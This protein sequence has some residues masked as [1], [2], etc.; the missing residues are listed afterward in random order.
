VEVTIERTKEI[1]AV[2]APGR[3]HDPACIADDDAIFGPRGIIVDSIQVLDALCALEAAFGIEIPD[4]DLTE[5]LFASVR[6]LA[7]YIDRCMNTKGRVD[8]M[9]EEAEE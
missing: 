7:G 6:H 8:A 1:I 4:E 3:Q 5:E 9:T 2:Y